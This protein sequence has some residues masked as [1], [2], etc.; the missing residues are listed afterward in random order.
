MLP[1]L[2][3]FTGVPGSRWSGIAREIK[4]DPSYDTT[5]RAPHRVYRHHNFNGHQEAYF[6]TGMEF[7]TSLNASNLYAPF[8]G[9]GT[10]LLLSHEWPYHFADIKELYPNAWIQLI[11]RPDQPSM[12]WWL[13]AGGFTITYPNYDCY[14]DIDGMWD[15]ICEQNKLI[16]DFAQKNNLQWLQH[17]K[18]TDIFITT[19]KG[20]ID[21]S[22]NT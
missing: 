19:Y 8:S 15:K 14:I 22:Q 17:H 2:I 6:G 12:D 7:D 3:F 1:K 10:K 18:H 16:L 20:K 9:E 21:E 5:D 11:Y 13:Q 4:E